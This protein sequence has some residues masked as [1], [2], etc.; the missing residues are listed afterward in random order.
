M[1][2]K[3]SA[4]FLLLVTFYLFQTQTGS[5]QTDL[6]YT[7][8]GHSAAV[9]S[10]DL[11]P[12][13][14]YLVSGAKDETIRVW[15][16]EKKQSTGSLRIT[17]SSVKRVCFKKDG[18]GFLASLYTKFVEVDFKSLSIKAT[19]KKAHTAFV[20]ACNYSPDGS[21]IVTSSWRDKSLV[22][23]KANGFKKLIET[24]E[25]NWVDNALINKNNS[26][27]FSG[28][29]D[30]LIKVW[31]I[32]TGDVIKT[33]AGHDDWVYDIELSA[34]EQV[35]YSA[36]LD[37]TIKVWDLKTNKNIYTLKGHKDG[38]IS[39]ALSPDGKY[40]AS[41]SM[42]NT[43]IIWDLSTQTIFKTLSDH[44]GAVTDLKFN[45]NGTELYSCSIDKTIKAWKAN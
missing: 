16:L 24:K 15:D 11:S 6:L 19:K 32:T 40:L 17:N 23:W 43:I 9:N 31:D 2:Q 10:I 38:I 26:L 14:N 37:K 25:I 5:A 33:L 12:Q 13:G 8:E 18:S 20:E 30:D 1:K 36:S 27:I 3:F 7:L 34:D 39:L 29:H 4:V 22:V 35:L 45:Q 44:T 28:S 41:G 21:L 42:D